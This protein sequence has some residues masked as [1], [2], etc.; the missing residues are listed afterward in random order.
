[1]EELKPTTHKAMARFR[2]SLLRR[3]SAVAWVVMII[4][5]A[6]AV[7]ES[8]FAEPQFWIPMTG[9]AALLVVSTAA[10]WD[11]IMA[12]T[13]APWIATG[14]LTGLIVG[15]TALA[16]IPELTATAQP[17]LFGIAAV[18]GL[19]LTWWAHA[20]V[21]V[22]IMGAISF[23]AFTLG[24][25]DAIPDVLAPVLTVAVVAA[26][27]ALVGLEFER[28]AVRSAGRELQID[29]QRLDF[30]RL[31]EVSATLARA[32]SLAEIVPHLIGTI[33]KYLDAQV[34]VVLLYNPDRHRLE[35]MSPIWVNGYPLDADPIVL[36]VAAAGVVT[37]TY[38]AGKPLHV[39][40]VDQDT[41][42][43]VLLKELGLKQ[44]LVAPLKVE[45]LRVGVIIVGDPYV[46]TFT[47]DQL[48]QLGS[49]AAPAGL[50]LS[51]IGRYEAQADMTRRLEE[52]AQMKS[53]FVS[54]VSHELRTP[55][56]SIIGSLDTVNRPELAPTQPT[57]QQLLSTARRQAGRLQRLI[58]DLLVVS[59][60]DRGAIPVHLEPIPVKQAFE[61]VNRVVSIE[62]TFAVEPETLTVEADRDHLSRILINLVENAAKYAAG[63]SVELFAWERGQRAMI[64]VVDHGPGIPETER[65]R[66]FERFTQVDQSDTRSKGGTGLGL[67]IVRS[68]AEV[69]NGS[70][71]VEETEG[72]GATFVVELPLAPALQGAHIR[73]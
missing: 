8:V 4:I 28:E 3:A 34:G 63:S 61:E 32:E 35:V 54:T 38:R 39:R 67:S 17:I 21:T 20:L 16:V 30:E 42:S 55:L 65:E 12:T 31:Y 2:A 72:G 37:Q 26:A 48:D 9:L 59:R 53:D 46:G 15:I 41:D 24:A 25:A 22:L 7:R 36:D 44:A 10:R 29:Q 43:H 70:V 6:Q 11:R 68:L 73:A 64:A 57:A 23:V 40:E 60:I 52:V 33:C 14:W 69:M 13:A 45:S 56:T 50:V 47:E 49:L 62:P 27:T 1:M 71:R 66:A 51:Q 18:S 58:D 5:S 19:L